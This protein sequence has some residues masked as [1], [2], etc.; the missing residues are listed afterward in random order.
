[1]NII[2]LLV[3]LL[4]IPLNAEAE[5]IIRKGEL[6][7]LERCVEIALIKQ[8]DIIAASNTV[9]V[10]M[11]RVGQAAADFYP[12]IDLTTG[13]SRI[14]SASDIS[15]SSLASNGSRGQYSG[16]VSLRQNIFDFGRTPAQ[17]R[18]QKFNLYSS[19][20]DLENA[21]EQ[22]I[23]NVKQ[24]YYG[25]LQTKRNRDVAVETVRQFELHLEQ[26]KGFYEV[27]VKPKFDVTTAEVDLSNARLNLIR[28]ENALRIAVTTLN[29]SMGVPDAPEY[30]IED[31]LSY[32]AY[33][34]TFENAIERAYKNRPDL[35]SVILRKRAAED[36]ITLA[37]TGYY[38]VLTGSASY[39]QTG[40]N[41]PLDDGWEAGITL[42]LPLF[43]GYLTRHQVG[44][45]RAN[46]EVLKANEEQLRQSIFLEVK[47]ASLNLREAEER[48]P[49]AELVVKQAEENLELA[50]GRYAAGVGSPIEVTDAQVGLSN[51]KT[52]YIQALYDHKVAQAN[53]EKAMGERR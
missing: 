26:A 25:V 36:S 38:P 14:S 10:N 1:M 5:D 12:Q 27:G 17:V 35:L 30:N 42:S 28:A 37:K 49:S 52:A 51:A 34:I 24:A 9:K 44:E 20:S 45:S 39:R 53:L 19:H 4:L 29:N 7:T 32:R 11:S 46:L 41:L 15:G 13:Y 48:V 8:P 16:S 33:S 43:S 21:S 40:E 23:L 18:I 22:T 47:Q 2:I 3:L 6:L 50:S 31:I